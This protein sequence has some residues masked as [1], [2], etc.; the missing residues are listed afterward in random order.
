MSRRRRRGAAAVALIGA[1]CLLLA[2]Q[3][4]AAENGPLV[5]D[6][7]LA[8]G[9]SRGVEFSFTFTGSLF[10]PLLHVGVP[11]ARTDLRSEAGATADAVAAQA[12]PGDLISSQAGENFPGVA[13]AG[14][15]PGKE[16][17]K[18]LVPFPGAGPVQAGAGHV[19]A[20][21][22]ADRAFGTATTA[23]GAFTDGEVPLVSVGSVR[24][25]SEGT[26]TGEG[27]V[28]LVRS[29]VKGLEVNLAD[30]F[31]IR[32]E[33]V[34][35]TAQAS[36]DGTEGVAEAHLTVGDVVVELGGQTFPATIDDRG[37]RLPE[38]L[39]DL[40]GVPLDLEQTIRAGLRQAGVSISTAGPIEI[41]EGATADAS[42]GG[43]VIGLTGEIPVVPVPQTFAQ[44]IGQ[45]QGSLPP[46][47]N[48]PICL[49]EDV[50]PDAPLPL[51][52]GPQLL[53]GPGSGMIQTLSLG[54]VNAFAAAS[55]APPPLDDDGGIIDGPLDPPIGPGPDLSPAPP[56]TDGNGDDGSANPG[57]QLTGLLARM[58]PGVLLVAGIVLLLVAAGAA[59]FPLRRPWRE[60]P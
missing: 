21:A 10:E 23:S 28:Q 6:S 24:V 44:L 20:A 16:S 2:P 55:L 17:V 26:R 1:A 53:P 52:I 43:L 5:F 57:S 37:I 33:S 7:Y 60:Q 42:V 56:V 35:S 38:P 46:E 47:V 4:G 22:A 13:L 9:T 51:C 41:V 59:V 12:Y 50:S 54:N 36:S 3:A 58:P 30:G 8:R 19:E 27:V 32:V 18:D 45:I 34:V 11:Y 49:Q 25:I 39:Q 40:A 15:P 14:Y 31:A 29:V 48:D